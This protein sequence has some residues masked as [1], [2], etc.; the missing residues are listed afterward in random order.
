MRGDQH[1]LLE[2][3]RRLEAELAALSEQTSEPV[4]MP[5]ASPVTNS[6]GSSDSGV[7]RRE[8]KNSNGSGSRFEEIEV[9]SDI[10]GYDV[11]ANT[12]DRPTSAARTSW[13]GWGGPPKGGSESV[14]NE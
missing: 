3:K 4:L 8:R 7:R 9:P 12:G 10:E 5:S 2:R 11:G 13:F 14:K 1:A 6:R